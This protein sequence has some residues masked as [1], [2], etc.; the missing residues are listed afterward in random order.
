M[1]QIVYE[2]WLWLLVRDA[3]SLWYFVRFELY[4]ASSYLGHWI[5]IPVLN[6]VLLHRIKRNKYGIVHFVSVLRIQDMYPRF[7]DPNFFI[8]D[9]G[10]KRFRIHIKEFKCF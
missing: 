9:P 7:P 6:T 1:R 8:P 10:S 3:V 4:E 5:C 2:Y